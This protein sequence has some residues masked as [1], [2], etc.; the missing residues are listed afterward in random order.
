MFKR[1]F[2]IGSRWSLP[3]CCEFLAERDVGRLSARSGWTE[4]SISTGAYR[5]G[6]GR[7]LR[8]FTCI[9][10]LTGAALLS[11]A[12]GDTTAYDDLRWITFFLIFISGGANGCSFNSSY[13]LL[14]WISQTASFL[15]L[16]G[17]PGAFSKFNDSID[18]PHL[19]GLQAGDSLKWVNTL[20][21]LRS[22]LIDGLTGSVTSVFRNLSLFWLRS[23]TSSSSALTEN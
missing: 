23:A 22:D 16:S 19:V 14:E 21:L 18:S 11:F 1:A 20:G 13:F 5:R 17:E 10:L 7:K 15:R 6:S 12:S 4:K 2:N 9:D 3:F 8:D